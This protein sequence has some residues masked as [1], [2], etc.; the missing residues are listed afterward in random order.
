MRLTDLSLLVSAAFAELS[1]QATGWP[2]VGARFL[3]RWLLAGEHGVRLPVRGLRIVEALVQ[4]HAASAVQSST[5]S[6]S[7]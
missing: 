5:L 3:G 2:G 4:R 6:P 1:E 7:T